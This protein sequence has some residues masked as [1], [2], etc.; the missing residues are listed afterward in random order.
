MELKVGHTYKSPRHGRLIHIL[1]M[2][3]DGA[4]IWLDIEWVETDFDN[5][6]DEM[7]VTLEQIQDWREVA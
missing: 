4:S 2:S 1:S 5:E 7:T 6:R 3:Q